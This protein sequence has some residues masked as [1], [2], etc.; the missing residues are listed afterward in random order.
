MKWL[1]VK[2]QNQYIKLLKKRILILEGIID[3]QHNDIQNIIQEY[4]NIKKREM[5]GVQ[6]C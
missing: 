1:I 6:K 3:R 5:I 2:I 4:E